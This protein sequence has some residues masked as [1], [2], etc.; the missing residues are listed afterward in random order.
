M[1]YIQLIKVIQPVEFVRIKNELD[2]YGIEYRTLFEE[3]LFEKSHIPYLPTGAIIMVLEKDHKRSI[4]V[5][6]IIGAYKEQN[7]VTII[8]A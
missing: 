5:L 1:E 4:E 2:N 8:S 3:N 6:K 7:Q